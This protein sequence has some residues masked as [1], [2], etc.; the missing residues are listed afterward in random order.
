[1]SFETWLDD[2][3]PYRNKNYKQETL[4]EV[5]DLVYWKVNAEED[6]LKVPISV[7]KYISEL[8][9]VVEKSYSEE[10]LKKAFFSGCQSERQIKPRIK[11]WEEWS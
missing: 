7:S 11:C 10:D 1:M 4:E 5:K 6:Y 9:N 8:E 3:Y 2:Y